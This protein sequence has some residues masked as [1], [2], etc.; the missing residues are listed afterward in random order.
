MDSLLSHLAGLKLLTCLV[1]GDHSPHFLS[2]SQNITMF[3]ALQCTEHC[4]QQQFATGWLR[5]FPE[6]CEPKPKLLSVG[7]SSTV[8]PPP[9]RECWRKSQD[10]KMDHQ[11]SFTGPMGSLNCLNLVYQGTNHLI[12]Q[13]GYRD[14]CI[15]PPKCQ[16]TTALLLLHFLSVKYTRLF[17]VK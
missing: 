13:F 4:W 8:K 9:W 7:S 5:L 14:C 1:I 16:I 12:T 15:L 11:K 10:E 3:N 6:A 17:G 2:F